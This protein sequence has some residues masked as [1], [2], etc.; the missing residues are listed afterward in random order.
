MIENYNKV[1]S[2]FLLKEKSNPELILTD[3]L[4]IHYLELPKFHKKENFNSHF[5]KW[6]AFF[7][8]EGQQEAIMETILKDDPFISKA[9]EKYNQFV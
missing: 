1:H 4:I 8:Y 3:H 7:K 9:H 6:L 5:E 2:C